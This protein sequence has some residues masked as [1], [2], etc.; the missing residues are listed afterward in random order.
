MKIKKVLMGMVAG[1]SL[2]VG[3]STISSNNVVKAESVETIYNRANK[4][5]MHSY[6]IKQEMTMSAKGK[7]RHIKQNM[8][9]NVKTSVA[10]AT[11][12]DGKTTVHMW[13]NNKYE[14]VK[15]KNHWYK[16]KLP[17]NLKQTMKQAKSL[18]K[19]MKGS[20][21][22]LNDNLIKNATLS[23]SGNNYVLSIAN[24]SVTNN[25]MINVITNVTKDLGFDSDLLENTKITNLTFTEIVNKK[26][27]NL[28]K[29][30]TTVS[31]NIGNMINTKTTQS[32]DGINKYNNLKVPKSIVKH[33]KLIK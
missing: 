12:T 27:K 29:I 4:T 15:V 18:S 2:L 3:A 25:Q 20:F 31:Y 16:M 23:T 8:F 21:L 13:M 26:T 5:K 32:I 28:K 30:N 1:A 24:N 22:G 33:A 6:H 9:F 10:K 14:Y 11:N 19:S 7:K 17:V